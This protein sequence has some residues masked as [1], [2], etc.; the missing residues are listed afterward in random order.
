MDPTRP[1][2][3]GNST[4]D[5]SS[6]ARAPRPTGPRTAETTMAEI[7]VAKEAGVEDTYRGFGNIDLD[8]WIRAS[9]ACRR[10]ADRHLVAKKIRAVYDLPSLTEAYPAADGF[11]AQLADGSLS[12]SEG[13]PVTFYSEMEDVPAGVV[14]IAPGVAY[15][16]R[17]ALVHAKRGA[18]KTTLLAWLVA[19][20]SAAGVK[21]LVVGDDDPQ[22]WRQRLSSFGADLTKIGGVPATRVAPANELESVVTDPVFGWDWV[23]VDNWR[24]WAGA[25]GIVDRGGYGD[26]A[27]ASLIDRLVSLVRRDPELALTLI[28]N[29]GWHNDSRSRDSSVVEDAVDVCKRIVTDKA[30]RVSVCEVAGKVRYGIPSAPLAWYLRRDEDGY[31]PTDVPDP[32]EEDDAAA[33]ERRE[34]R[35]K[36]ADDFIEV[37][38]R[39]FPGGS[40][41]ACYAAARE[42]GLKIR[43][44]TFLDRFREGGSRTLAPIPPEPREPPL[45]SNR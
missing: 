44:G 35:S 3:Q 40:A 4:G 29:Q 24:T 41:R 21:T 13:S 7:P 17:A 27:A 26:T 18:G 14:E 23:V 1:E 6:S 15:R 25:C 9:P 12:R 2:H 34:G 42:S 36:L 22:S 43:K 19:R 8:E 11:L 45:F 39:D 5:R 31:D 28:H 30:T 33:E 20:A 16:G 32:D 37:W 38:L 10:L